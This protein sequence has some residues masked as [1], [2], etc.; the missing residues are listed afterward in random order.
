MAVLATT[1]ADS[2]SAGCAK[3]AKVEENLILILRTIFGSLPKTNSTM[4]SAI[5]ILIVMN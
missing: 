2:L 3:V 4:M 1:P 5:A